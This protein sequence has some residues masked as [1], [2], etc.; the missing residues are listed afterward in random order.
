MTQEEDEMLVGLSDKTN[1]R[2]RTITRTRE[3]FQ[4]Y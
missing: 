2:L 1:C 3:A 4:K